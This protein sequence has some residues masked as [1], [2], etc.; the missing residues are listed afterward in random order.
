MYCVIDFIGI[1]KIW[2]E[3]FIIMIVFF[4]NIKIY[5][6]VELRYLFDKV[7]FLFNK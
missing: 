6:I 5:I 3:V 7:Y 2:V 1:V 4:M